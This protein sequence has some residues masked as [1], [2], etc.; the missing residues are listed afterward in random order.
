MGGSVNIVL[1]TCALLWWT[2]EPAQLSKTALWQLNQQKMLWVSSI[3]LWEIGLKLKNNKLDIGMSIDKYVALLKELGTLTI[4]PVDE[5]VWLKN[6]ALEWDHRD[7]ADRTIVATAELL[8][9]QIATT[10]GLIAHHYPAIF[11]LK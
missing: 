7:P 5:A 1:D 8:Q 2:L 3:S 10:D 9:A 4:V 6:L 11:A